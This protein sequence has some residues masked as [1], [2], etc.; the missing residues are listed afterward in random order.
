MVLDAINNF[1]NLHRAST[2]VTERI[3][4]TPSWTALMASPPLGDG[5][6]SAFIGH[7][8]TPHKNM[9]WLG[10]LLAS[11]PRPR[12]Q[13]PARELD[14]D[15]GTQVPRKFTS[16]TTGRYRLCLAWISRRHRHPLRGPPAHDYLITLYCMP[17][18]QSSLLLPKA[19]IKA[20]RANSPCPAAAPSHS[21][22]S[23][24]SLYSRPP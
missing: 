11:L 19:F 20:L 4:S 5:C 21:Y 7:R 15:R 22:S 1:D 16:T 18:R 10:C 23:R 8:P 24:P 14:D 12:Y 17:R 13:R 9:V 2:Y 6:A 3:S